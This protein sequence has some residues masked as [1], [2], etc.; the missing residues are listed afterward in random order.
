MPAIESP[1]GSSVEFEAYTKD[2]IILQVSNF[3]RGNNATV[4]TD[5][6]SK[7]QDY[8]CRRL[9]EGFCM[10]SDDGQP[11]AKVVTLQGIRSKAHEV[12]R[13][14]GTHFVE[15][16]VAEK[17]AHTCASCEFNDRTACPTCVGLVSWGERFVG[18]RKTS[19]N[20]YLGIC[21]KDTLLLP[22]KVYLSRLPI[23]NEKLPGYCWARRA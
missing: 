19:Y 11:R 2:A 7:I 1:G 10:G 9:P 16:G 21:A 6:W 5:L 22:V 17:R 12:A 18:G 14:Q 8:M 13:S 15:K 4:P 23:C 20:Q 3:Y